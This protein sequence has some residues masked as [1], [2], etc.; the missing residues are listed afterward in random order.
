M[1]RDGSLRKRERLRSAGGAHAGGKDE[2]HCTDRHSDVKVARLE[3]AFF[4]TLWRTRMRLALC[5]GVADFIASRSFRSV[6]SVSA[7]STPTPSSIGSMPA[8]AAA[9]SSGVRLSS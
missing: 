2:R 3:S 8:A 4:I 6:Y 1:L 7:I 5:S 9:R